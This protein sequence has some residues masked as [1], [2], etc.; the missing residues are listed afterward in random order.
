MSTGSPSD[1]ES[2]R[3]QATLE[4]RDR[5]I[6]C[7]LCQLTGE[8]PDHVYRHLQVGHRKSAIADALVAV[9]SARAGAALP[10]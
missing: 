5:S 3:T 7:P 8:S 6:E 1:D 9:V 2:A 10:E 4:S